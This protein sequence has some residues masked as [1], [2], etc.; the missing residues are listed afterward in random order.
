MAHSV[1][2]LCSSDEMLSRT[3]VSPL[4]GDSNT[5]GLTLQYQC[6]TKLGADWKCDPSLYTDGASVFYLPFRPS[7]NDLKLLVTSGAAEANKHVWHNSKK[8]PPHGLPL[9]RLSF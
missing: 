5:V 8:T 1:L 6:F 2:V 3:Y 9:S 4:G 7:G